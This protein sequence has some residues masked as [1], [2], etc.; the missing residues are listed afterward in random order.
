MIQPIHIAPGAAEFPAALNRRLDEISSALEALAETTQ[1]ATS[2]RAAWAGTHLQ[3]LSVRPAKLT[4]GTTWWETDRTVLY[5]V[6]DNGAA[7]VW[8]YAS[9]RMRRALLNDKPGDL[10]AADDGFEF[11]ADDFRHVWGWTGSAWEYL[12][13]PSGIFVFTSLDPGTGWALCDGSTVTRSTSAGGSA[14][15]TLPDLR[16]AYAKGAAAYS[17]T[18][19]AATDGSIT[20]S[21]GTTSPSGTINGP[22]TTVQSGTGATVAAVGG[23]VT[24]AAHSHPPGTLAVS[25]GEPA[26]ADLLPYYRL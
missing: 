19:V 16:G 18:V 9:G 17:A 4:P 15:V 12:D 8:Q 26:H 2:G 25:G 20:G 23:S 6:A 11:W 13:T 1:A 10:G 3:R 21:T 5:V 24:V 7:R 22:G 14:S